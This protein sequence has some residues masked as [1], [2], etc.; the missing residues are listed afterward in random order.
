MSDASAT[1]PATPAGTAAP[2]RYGIIGTGMM[3]LEHLR[4]LAAVPGAQI[5]AVAD[6]FEP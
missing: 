1:T 6:N 2:L 3:G 4:N 5:T